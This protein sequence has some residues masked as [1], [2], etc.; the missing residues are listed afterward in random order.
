MVEADNLL[1]HDDFRDFDGI[2]GETNDS[3]II[4]R[5]GCDVCYLFSCHARDAVKVHVRH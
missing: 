5:V 1:T 4:I 3:T 2:T